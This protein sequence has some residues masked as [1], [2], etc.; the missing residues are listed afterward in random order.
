MKTT[1]THNGAN[2]ERDTSAPLWE[3]ELR[4]D[5]FCRRMSERFH[6]VWCIN[7]GEDYENL[8]EKQ[9]FHREDYVRS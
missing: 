1:D 7:H 2:A 5:A 9:S 4:V 6:K 8:A 3:E